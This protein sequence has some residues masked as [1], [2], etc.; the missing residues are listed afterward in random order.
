MSGDAARNMHADG[1]YLGFG[2]VAKRVGPDTGQSL[3]ALGADAEVAAG[4]NEHL[5]QAANEID[6][7]HLG[8]EAAQVEDRIG[9]QL[10]RT[11]EGNVA[12][13]IDV[14]E[15]DAALGEE[16]RRS[17]HVFK[18]GIASQGD[19]RRMLQ[20]QQGIADTTG[21]AQVEQRAL[22]L[23]RRIV[24]DQAEM[25]NVDDHSAISGQQLAVSSKLLS[26]AASVTL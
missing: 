9:H 17:D 8:L 25:K 6:G 24:R 3:D 7:S 2:L 12:A 14:E 21:L 20:Q 19:N 23:Q 10:A 15:L 16:L 5:F 22:Q 1:G 18:P 26:C 13:A 11:M 4:A